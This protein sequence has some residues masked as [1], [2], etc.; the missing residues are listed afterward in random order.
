M[1]KIVD[2]NKELDRRSFEAFMIMLH[3][4]DHKKLKITKNKDKK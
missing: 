4:E 2:F 3:T 1:R